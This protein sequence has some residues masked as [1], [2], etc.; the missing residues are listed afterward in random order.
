MFNKK[1]EVE[2]L[3]LLLEQVRFKRVISWDIYKIVLEDGTIISLECTEQD[4]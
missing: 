4:C 3:E 2:S 1:E